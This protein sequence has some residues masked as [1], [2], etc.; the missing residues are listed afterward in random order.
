MISWGL[1]SKV[2]VKREDERAEMRWKLRLGEEAI[3]VWAR[4][5]EVMWMVG[6]IV[7]TTVRSE[8]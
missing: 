3:L 6:E 2:S 5:M 1:C 7:S 8:T 4:L